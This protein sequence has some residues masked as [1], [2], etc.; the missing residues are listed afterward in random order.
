MTTQWIATGYALEMTTL[1][2]IARR[3]RSERRGNPSCI[4]GRVRAMRFPYRDPVDRHAFQARDDRNGGP[5]ER[6]E[7]QPHASFHPSLFT[8]LLSLFNLLSSKS[9]FNS[10]SQWRKDADSLPFDIRLSLGRI[11]GMQRAKKWLLIV[12][13][14]VALYLY[15]TCSGRLPG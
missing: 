14:G 1:S 10:S 3:E 2:V 5:K 13:G 4:E 11:K 8:H 7:V 6:S 9:P 12:L 15:Q